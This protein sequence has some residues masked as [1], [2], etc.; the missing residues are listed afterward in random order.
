MATIIPDGWQALPASGHAQR[1]L[2]TLHTLARGLPAAYTVLHG[3]HWT[4]IHQGHQVTGEVDFVVLAPSGR[5]LL[6]EQKSGFLSENEHGL[7]QTYGDRSL[8]V[9]A[10]MARTADAIDARLQQFC[11]GAKTPIESL[12]YCPDY[13]VRQ[14]GSAG[15]DPARIVDASRRAHLCRAI[16]AILPA[17]EPPFAT[18]GEV[19][20]FFT[21][22]LDLVQDVAAVAGQAG[23]LYTRLSDGLAT[24]A[25]RIEAEPHRLRVTATAGSGKTQLALAVFRDAIDARRR[26]LY[27]CYNRPLADHIALLVPPGGEVATYHQLC[28]RISRAQGATPDFSR[29]G[30]FKALEQHFDAYQPADTDMFDEL[31]VDEGQ[32]FEQSWVPNLMKLLRPA[33]RAWWLED[34]MQNLYGRAPLRLPGWVGLRSEVNYR[35]PREVLAAIKRMIPLTTP[36][37]TGSPLSGAEVEILTYSD[38]QD[39]L[40]Q[41]SR[42]I[43]N[44]IGAGF[45]RDM[46]AVITY[47]GREGSTFSGQPRIGP[48]PLKAYSGRY[49]LLGNPLFSEGDIAIDSVHRFKGQSAPCVVF[50]EI[51]FPDAAGGPDDAAC[52][53]LFVG[54]TRATMKLVL[55]MSERA[56]RGLAKPHGPA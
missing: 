50:T 38:P 28:D 9:P 48:Y 27:A 5:V 7:A 6:I 23:A 16:E 19:L 14:A 44:C 11:K 49:D 41:T 42:A 31:I 21:G 47:R 36:V 53:R 25:R 56:A 18:R 40:R 43:T 3:V 51:D 10:Q 4:R 2:Q 37:A 52:R 20:R 22:M 29:P 35:S 26:P 54:A 1:E 24:W 13:T 55:V 46:I 17:A 12:L 39:L 33:G 32:D 15:L 30:A 8:S 45:K 34:P